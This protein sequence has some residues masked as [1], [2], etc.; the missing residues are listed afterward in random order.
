VKFSDYA[1]VKSKQIK[2]FEYYGH[3]LQVLDAVTKL[4]CSTP[5]RDGGD[6]CQDPC[7]IKACALTKGF[8]GCWECEKLMA[9]EKFEF[10]KLFSG[11]LPKENARKI[12][13]YGPTEWVKH[14]SKFYTWL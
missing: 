7:P 2:D 11:D 12:K 13:E 14:R 8:T 5:C 4:K 1:R 3:F 9:C 6:G 10:L